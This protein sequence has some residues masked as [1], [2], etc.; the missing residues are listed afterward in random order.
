MRVD[1]D[2]KERIKVFFS[3]AFESYKLAMGC[4]LSVFVS[5]NCDYTEKECSVSESFQPSSM[6]NIATISVN[7]LTFATIIALYAVEIAR[8]KLFLSN[9]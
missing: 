8:E 9:A 6:L 2:L 4:F 1:N 7:G 3:F 5:H